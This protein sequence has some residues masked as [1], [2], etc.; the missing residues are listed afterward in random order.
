[1]ADAVFDPH[2]DSGSNSPPLMVE[3]PLARKT[4][5]SGYTRQDF[6]LDHARTLFPNMSHWSTDE[7]HWAPE[8]VRPPL[9]C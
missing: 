8:Q 3:H 7:L 6:L 5:P 9:T 4:A 2:S 1:M